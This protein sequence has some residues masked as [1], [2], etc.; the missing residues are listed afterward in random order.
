MTRGDEKKMK[1]RAFLS[2]V[3]S[4]RDTTLIWHMNG[5]FFKKILF[6]TAQSSADEFGQLCLSKLNVEICV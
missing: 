6:I 2:A 5:P 4:N 3:I 1:Q